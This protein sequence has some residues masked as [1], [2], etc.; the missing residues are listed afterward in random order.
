MGQALR[1]VNIFGRTKASSATF[2]AGPS[3]PRDRQAMRAQLKE[4]LC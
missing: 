4:A 3:I 1:P 2:A